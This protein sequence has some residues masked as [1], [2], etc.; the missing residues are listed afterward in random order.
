M[1]KESIYDKYEAVIGLEVHAQLMTESKMY[2][3]D[4]TEFGLAPNTNVSPIS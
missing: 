1:E 4:S 2:C 3:S